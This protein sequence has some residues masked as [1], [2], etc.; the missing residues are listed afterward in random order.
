MGAFFSP[1]AKSLTQLSHFG[2]KQRRILLLGLDG[3]GKTT[4]LFRLHLGHTISTIPT[5]GFNVEKV[6]HRNIMFTAWDLGGQQRIRNLWGHYILGTDAI[7][8]VVD[9]VDSERLAE[10]RE[11]LRQIMR[12]DELEEVVL[13]VLANKQDLKGALSPSA[14]SRELRLAEDYRTLVWHVQGCVATQGAGLQ[15][16]LDFL[17]RTLNKR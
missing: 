14:I 9:S 16:A 5:I 15:E 2:Q 1:C 8:Y 17:V 10:A 6:K 3:A 4:V 11:E 13:L 7:L 12:S